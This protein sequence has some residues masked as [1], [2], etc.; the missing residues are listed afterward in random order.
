[1][2]LSTESL[3]RKRNLVINFSLLLGG[4][5]ALLRLF[6]DGG[7]F[8]FPATALIVGLSLVCATLI[9]AQILRSRDGRRTVSRMSARNTVADHESEATK[10][11]SEFNESVH[12]TAALTLL[13][14]TAALGFGIVLGGTALFLINGG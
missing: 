10:L 12:T 3:V 11:D 14:A 4:S 1:M 2:K 9:P 13:E 7:R 8:G 5:T 6:F